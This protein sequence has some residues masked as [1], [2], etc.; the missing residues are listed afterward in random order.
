MAQVKMDQ[1]RVQSRTKEICVNDAGECI[2][3]PMGSDDF[4][5]S[6]YDLMSKIESIG[7]EQPIAGESDI[8]MIRR[9]REK[10]KEVMKQI[11]EVFGE[12]CCRKV[13]GVGVPMDDVLADFFEQLIPIIEK[14]S[15][16][17]QKQ[18]MEKYNRSRGAG[19]KRQ[20][21]KQELIDAHLAQSNV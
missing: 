16:E 6:F 18:I 15:D 4:L 13:F 19:K 9:H 20:R 12:D 11:D 1:I 8:D 10:K 17:R 21:T 2:Q 14:C 3:I 7:E 5:I